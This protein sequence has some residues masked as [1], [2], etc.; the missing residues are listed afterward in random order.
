VEDVTRILRLLPILIAA[1]LLAGE[2][3][4]HTGAPAAHAQTPGENG[5][6]AYYDHYV[7][8]GVQHIGLFV[9][10]P[11]T[12]SGTLLI[13]DV[14]QA[15][16][17][18]DGHKLA[19]I[20]PGALVVINEDGSGRMDIPVPGAAYPSWSPDGNRIVFRYGADLFT[21]EVGQTTLFD[22]TNITNTPTTVETFTDWGARGT[23]I[24]FVELTET[25]SRLVILTLADS[26][27][28]YV[29]GAEG[30]LHMSWSPDEATF[31]IT[32]VNG[33][34]FDILVVPVGGGTPTNLTNTPAATESFAA[35][36]PDGKKIAYAYDDGS[37]VD[38]YGV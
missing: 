1:L 14:S 37:A 7:D 34:H 31:A 13:P 28:S 29:N 22:L 38:Y 16:W 4:R 30:L 25:G 12:A 2:E 36:S 19:Y 33:D 24:A 32:R 3:A 23:R 8:H 10:T 5:K 9:I 20:E 6:I 26:S 11:G 18:P 17:S 27:R 35:W 15:A 21:V